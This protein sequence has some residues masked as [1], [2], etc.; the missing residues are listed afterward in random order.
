MCRYQV[1]AWNKYSLDWDPVAEWS[2]LMPCDE[3][4]KCMEMDL[5][6][7]NDNTAGNIYKG[8]VSQGKFCMPNEYQWKTCP[9]NGI[10]G[11]P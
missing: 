4:K 10:Q 1:V 11:A 2:K 6:T 9:Q 5:L 7:Y 8:W 3:L